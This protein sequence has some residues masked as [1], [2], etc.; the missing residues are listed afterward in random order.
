M[1]VGSESFRELL[2]FKVGSVRPDG[3]MD[4]W[5]GWSKEDLNGANNTALSSKCK[6]ISMCCM[7]SMVMG[8]IGD[9]LWNVSIVQRRLHKPE[10]RESLHKNV[11][12][13]C[14]KSF[15]CRKD[16]ISQ[17]QSKLRLCCIR[18]WMYTLL[19]SSV[20]S[21]LLW[22]IGKSSNRQTMENLGNL[23]NWGILPLSQLPSISLLWLHRAQ[24]P[25][26]MIGDIFINHLI[27]MSEITAVGH[28][29]M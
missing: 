26:W 16:P 13:W 14:Q 4:L 21:E 5:A 28:F 22:K 1:W 27:Y 29:F 15:V 25:M 24:S 18:S 2:A 23:A 17:S 20:W 9:V 19:F 12:A 3:W 11:D 6:I 7:S 8:C 10:I